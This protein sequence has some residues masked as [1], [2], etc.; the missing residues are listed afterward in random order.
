[1][2]PRQSLS[3]LTNLAEAMKFH[4]VPKHECVLRIDGRMVLQ[5]NNSDQMNFHYQGEI[6]YFDGQLFLL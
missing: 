4:L 1:M 5:S 2:N 6:Y 3:I